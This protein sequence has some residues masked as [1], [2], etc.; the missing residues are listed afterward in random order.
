MNNKSDI[1]WLFISQMS[2]IRQAN[3]AETSKKGQEQPDGSRAEPGGWLLIP[4]LLQRP[5][6]PGA[7]SGLKQEQQAAA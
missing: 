6:L 7:A 5:H 4:G 3:W 2:R 1:C